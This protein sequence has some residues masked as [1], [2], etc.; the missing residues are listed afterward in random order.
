MRGSLISE[1]EVTNISRHGFWLILDEEEMFLSFEEFPWFKNAS[2][3][4][5]LSVSLLQPDHLF[6]PKLDVDLAVDSIKH[7]ELFPLRSKQT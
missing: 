5:I 1:P 3:D 2:V 4:D 7:P 6:W